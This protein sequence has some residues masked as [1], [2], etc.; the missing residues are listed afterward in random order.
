MKRNLKS[1]LS[2]VLVFAMLLCFTV[3]GF[4]KSG[5]NKNAYATI[6]TA[7]DF[8]DEKTGAF[9]RFE[10]IL[11]IMKNDGLATPHS[12]LC[13]GDYSKIWPDYATP[14][15]ANVKDA[16]TSVYPD[17]SEGSVVCIQGNHDFV[18]CGFTKTG[19]YDMGAYN[20]YVINEN[21]F[22]W[23]QFLRTPL[24]IKN[25]ANDL[26]D[27]LTSLIDS[28]DKRPVIIMTHVPLHHTDRTLSGDNMYSGYLFDVINENAKK[29]DIVFIFGHNHSS[30]YDDYIGGAV[31]FMAP[32]EKIR[33]PLKNK[34]GDDCYTEETLNF[35]YT[36]CGY[37]GYSGNSDEN[38]STSTLTVGAIQLTKNN[39]HFVKYSENGLFKTYDVARKN[40]STYVSDATVTTTVQNDFVYYIMTSI[41]EVVEAFFASFAK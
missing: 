33:I 12:M 8:Q 38:G 37:V 30:D 15:V 9:D 6:I 25:T 5:L 10:N 40:C 35:T 16:Y 2:L 28:G 13:G 19:Y 29:L 24:H 22:P 1:A 11:T 39:I 20:L 14:G 18:S 23:N 4:A 34:F 21:D 26:N 32:G 17:A 27:T 7:S 31:N 41:F 36:N 3:I